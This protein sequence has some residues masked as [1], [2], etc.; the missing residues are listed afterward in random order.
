MATFD[1]SSAT[2]SVSLGPGNYGSRLS[3]YDAVDIVIK[4]R[5]DSIYYL[6][7]RLLGLSNVSFVGGC[8]CIFLTM[9]CHWFHRVLLF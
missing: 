2:S 6:H 5:C 8:G 4:S 1:L 9:M 3:T 7:R